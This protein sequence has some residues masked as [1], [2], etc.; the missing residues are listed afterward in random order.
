M[1]PYITLIIGIS[2]LIG[3]VVA[4]TMYVGD[5]KADNKVQASE[6]LALQGNYEKL[7]KKIDNQNDKLNALLIKAGVNPDKITIK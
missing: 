5:I 4:P 1:Q 2:A 7:E 6:I 3:S